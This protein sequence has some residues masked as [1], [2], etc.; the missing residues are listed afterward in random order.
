MGHGDVM[1]DIRM[2]MRLVPVFQKIPLARIAMWIWNREKRNKAINEKKKKK[3]EEKRKQS[4]VDQRTRI[5]KK[6]TSKYLVS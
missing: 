6:K 4:E 5:S 1:W 2:H 3:N